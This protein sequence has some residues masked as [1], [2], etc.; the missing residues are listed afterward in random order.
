MLEKNKK[1][2][3]LFMMIL[4]L[5]LGTSCILQKKG[6]YLEIRTNN[7]LFEQTLAKELLDS[8]SDKSLQSKNDEILTLGFLHNFDVKSEDDTTTIQ[9]FAQKISLNMDTINT[10]TK[11]G[12]AEIGSVSIKKHY[13]KPGRK[14]RIRI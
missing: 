9:I 7:K 6:E 1:M 4:S 8:I 5:L 10:I 14:E 11:D 2:K 13:L 12:I 3:N